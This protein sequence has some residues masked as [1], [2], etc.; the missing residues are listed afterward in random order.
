MFV[1]TFVMRLVRKVAHVGRADLGMCLISDPTSCGCLMATAD[2]DLEDSA[3]AT[4]VTVDGAV[5]VAT[6][7]AVVADGG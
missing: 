2:A 3:E 6:G 4:T 7:T 5:V 1:L